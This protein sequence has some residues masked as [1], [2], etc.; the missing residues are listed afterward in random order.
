MKTKGKLITFE[1][2]EGS[3]KSTQIDLLADNLKDKGIDVLIT[4]E[5]GGTKIGQD[6]RNILLDND[7]QN[8]DYK[9]ELL[10]YV[11]DRRQHIAEKILPALK[12]GKIVISDRFFDSTFAIQKARCID[13]DFIKKV[14]D[15]AI[16]WN[17][18]KIIPDLTFLLDIPVAK[19]FERIESKRGKDRLEIENENFYKK[20]RKNYL[21]IANNNSKRFVVVNADKEKE[22]LQ[23]K[24]LSK[25]LER[26]SK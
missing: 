14:N 4:K 18:K 6:I 15:I 13:E 20:V 12:D 7:N 10:L 1:G 2:P 9:T 24:I 26:L 11:A 21:E 5:P 23:E 25:F 8:M 16:S 3:G 19:G 17:D 22:K